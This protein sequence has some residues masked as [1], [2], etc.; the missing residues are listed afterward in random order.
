MKNILILASVLLL[1]LTALP[2]QAQEA[3]FI[4]EHVERL[5]N[6]RKY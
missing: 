5:E 3:I 4:K 6:S 1:N 2:L